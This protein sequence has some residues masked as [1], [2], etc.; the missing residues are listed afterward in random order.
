[1]TISNDYSNYLYVPEELQGVRSSNPLEKIATNKE[2]T[3]AS[4]DPALLAI[5][6]QLNYEQSGLTQGV[7]NINSAL[8]YLQIGDSALGEQSDIL[9]TIREKTLQAATDTTSDDQRNIIRNDISKLLEQFDN[10]ASSTSYG[11]NSILQKNQDDKGE[12]NTFD[13]QTGTDSQDSTSLNPLQS[14]TQG[15]GLDGFLQDGTFSADDARTF[16]DTID[17]ASAKLQDFRSDIGST[18]QQLESSYTSMSAQ[19]VNNSSALST[20]SNVDFAKEVSS[21]SKQNILAQIGSFGQSQAN[22]INQQS[23]L[24]L[25]S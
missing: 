11:D 24:R 18:A 6:D 1:M 16:L 7:Q 20:I 15:L 12:S 3:K 19:V 23:V 21:F 5:S 4:D 9:N 14:N 25:L 2:L 8:S 13:A 10:I 17:Q 22:N